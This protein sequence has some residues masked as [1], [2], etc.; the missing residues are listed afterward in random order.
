MLALLSIIIIIVIYSLLSLLILTFIYSLALGNCHK[1]TI[2]V[3]LGPENSPP[4]PSDIPLREYCWP[5][6]TFRGVYYLGGII[7]Q[8]VLKI[9]GYK[10]LTAKCNVSMLNS[11][12]THG[13]WNFGSKRCNLIFFSFWFFPLLVS[14]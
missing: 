13:G 6:S 3:S 2:P 10:L 11:I 1:L 4:P 8:N 14:I 7:W 9:F 12:K 5:K